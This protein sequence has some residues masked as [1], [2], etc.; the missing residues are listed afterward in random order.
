[1]IYVTDKNLFKN[2]KK[3]CDTK[4]SLSR[5]KY[6]SNISDLEMQ[7]IP[8]KINYFLGKEDNAF[9][10]KKIIPDIIEIFAPGN[11]NIIQYI[12][13][14]FIKK[15]PDIEFCM[16][17]T[18]LNYYVEFSLR[19]D[20]NIAFSKRRLIDYLTSIDE[21]QVIILPKVKDSRIKKRS[22]SRKI[23][24]NILFFWGV[25]LVAFVM[26]IYFRLKRKFKPKL[27]WRLSIQPKLKNFD[28]L[29]FSGDRADPFV[30]DVGDLSLIA[31]EEL[32]KGGAY[33][34]IRVL[35]V[36]QQ[37]VI[38]QVTIDLG[39]HLSY[40]CL[41]RNPWNP[42]EVFIIPESTLS[43]SQIIISINIMTLKFSLIENNLPPLGDPTLVFSKGKFLIFGCTDSGRNIKEFNSEFKVFRSRKFPFDWHDG[44]LLLQ[45]FNVCRGAGMFRLENN[46]IKRLV[47]VSKFG[48]YG[49]SYFEQVVDMNLNTVD[50][51]ALPKGSSQKVH[52]H[53]YHQSEKFKIFDYKEMRS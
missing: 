34:V 39:V 11:L 21:Q 4:N 5:I 37:E 15:Y 27:F 51:L 46:Q 6:I 26:S 53:H 44:I 18:E 47:Q 13:I 8:D 14:C 35:K 12:E 52:T 41:C 25:W 48:S 28:L 2:I 17:N 3:Y 29:E 23:P 22:P 16:K 33:A 19:N 43:G 40:P 42:V 24:D 31:F 36:R 10:I 49:D 20:I 7:I 9:Q 32:L 50:Q 45:G 1:M 30:L 38:D